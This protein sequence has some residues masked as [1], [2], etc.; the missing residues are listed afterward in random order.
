MTILVVS[1]SN[2]VSRLPTPWFYHLIPSNLS[3][4][5]IYPAKNKSMRNS[6]YT[7]IGKN[8]FTAP[9]HTFESKA[10]LGVGDTEGTGPVTG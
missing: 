5:D 6:F 3:D 7:T 1:K 9:D 8:S 4:G 10:V 2:R